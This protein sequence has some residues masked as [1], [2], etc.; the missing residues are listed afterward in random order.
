MYAFILVF[1]AVVLGD[2]NS[3]INDLKTLSRS[4]DRVDAIVTSFRAS[5]LH[6]IGPIVHLQN[7]AVDLE[8]TILTVTQRFLDHAVLDSEDTLIIAP[9]VLEFI[10]PL[11]RALIHIG[12]AKS[13]FDKA[14]LKHISISPIV[15]GHIVLLKR[16]AGLLVGATNR[17]VDPDLSSIVEPIAEQINNGFD[18]Q[19]NIIYAHENPVI[20]GVR[21]DKSSALL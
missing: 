18:Y 11:Q 3:L 4:I 21:I 19:L 12:E 9:S 14:V 13:Q 16:L 6:D 2:V 8:S 15:K 20:L 10:S 5:T 17:T 1:A 7:A